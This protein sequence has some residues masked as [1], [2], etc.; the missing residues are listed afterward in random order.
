[1]IP[2]SERLYNLDIPIVGL[3]GG[4]GTGKSSV[5]KILEKN[6]YTTINADN[7]IHQIYQEQEVQNYLKKNAKGCL[8]GTQVNFAKLR[9][10]FFNNQELK[11]ELTKILYSYL[12]IYF[13]K[14][15]PKECDFVIYEI[16]LLFEQNLT[17]KFDLVVTVSTTPEN[18]K[19]RL[20]SRDPEM[21]DK[22]RDQILEN[23]LDLKIKEK[24]SHY[25]I[26]NNGSI[27]QL[28]E[29]TLKT[30]DKIRLQAFS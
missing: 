27:E 10:L 13:K 1:M 19:L 16:P 15:I 17:N 3:T 2:Q 30:F 28:E 18:Q 24:N 6:G 9:E 11:L 22:T 21:N 12:E 20:K 23:Q 8:E 29:V 26:N 25:I 4:I 7:L 14:S 5:G